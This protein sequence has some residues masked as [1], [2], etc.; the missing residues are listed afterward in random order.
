MQFNPI[1]MESAKEITMFPIVN[2]LNENKVTG[3]VCLYRSIKKH[4]LWKDS[5]V[6]TPFEAWID[7]LLRAS[8][9]D[10]K[11]PVGVDFIVVKRGQ[12]L[13]SQLQ[14]SKEWFWSRKKVT[15]FLSSL[16]KD[17][18]ISVKTTT[19]WSMI[20]IC[21]YESYQDR[22]T[23]KEQQRNNNGTTTEH[24]QTLETLKEEDS[25]GAEAP[26]KRPK[27]FKTWTKDEFINELAQYKDYYPKDI[28]NNFFKYWAEP[29]PSGRMKFQMEKT[30]ATAGRLETW[31]TNEDKWNRK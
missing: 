24:I 22:R 23:T 5:R 4:W 25:I 3:Y 15:H 7:L 11:E 27:S 6:K 20:T 29:S 13:T 10:Q 14:L 2:H 9:E 30:W 26:P 16:Q 21:N 19:K 8:H 1:P 28:L 31:S 17:I 12:V 18:M